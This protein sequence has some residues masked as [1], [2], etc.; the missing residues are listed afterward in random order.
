M[1]PFHQTQ[2]HMKVDFCP[3]MFLSHVPTEQTLRLEICM[4]ASSWGV[5][6]GTAPEWVAREVGLGRKE[7][8]PTG[9]SWIEARKGAGLCYFMGRQQSRCHSGEW[10]ASLWLRT[11]P[12]EGLSCQPLLGNTLGSWRSEC[13]GSEGG[14]WAAH[15]AERPSLIPGLGRS[16]GEGKGYPL[17]YSGLE[18]FMN[19]IAKNWTR[20][21]NFHIHIHIPASTPAPLCHGQPEQPHVKVLMGGAWGHE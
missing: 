9:N 14:I 3:N 19:C 1:S 10:H 18:N 17:Q 13:L 16:P 11:N 15:I 2:S 20:P 5:V 8:S 21:S 6:S 7:Y 12:G 4:Q